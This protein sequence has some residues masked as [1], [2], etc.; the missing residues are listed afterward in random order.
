MNE[1]L[2]LGTYNHINW[3]QTVCGSHHYKMH[4]YSMRHTPRRPLTFCIHY[5]WCNRF[6]KALT[7][8]FYSTGP[9]KLLIIQYIFN[10]VLR[11]L[12]FTLEWFCTPLHVALA[13]KIF[14]KSRVVIIIIFKLF[15]H[16]IKPGYGLW[17]FCLKFDK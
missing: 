6:Q 14:F 3:C 9:K 1:L 12:E 13:S 5:L 17:N 10:L 16:H 2:E 4:D 7:S 11:H 15:G 8:L